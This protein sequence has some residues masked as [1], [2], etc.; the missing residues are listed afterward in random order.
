MELLAA[1][2]IAVPMSVSAF[3]EAELLIPVPDQRSLVQAV[4]FHQVLVVDP[5]NALGLVSTNGLR[6]RLGGHR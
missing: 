5:A 6:I 3:G 2:N 1:I 4:L